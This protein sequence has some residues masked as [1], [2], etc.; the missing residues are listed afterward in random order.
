[1]DS[2]SMF[3]FIRVVNKRPSPK[4]LQ[5]IGFENL[6][7]IEYANN[8]LRENYNHFIYNICN[9]NTIKSIS[10]DILSGYKSDNEIKIPQVSVLK[11]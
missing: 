3:H 4:I 1:M 6:E 5:I 9:E 11:I 10:K 8:G 2:S 7:L